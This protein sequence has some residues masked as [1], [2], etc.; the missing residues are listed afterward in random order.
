MCKLH[1]MLGVF[2]DIL[3]V[4]FHVS[5]IVVGILN[6]PFVNLCGIFTTAFRK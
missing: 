5:V 1:D 4:S 2:F 6:V 3:R